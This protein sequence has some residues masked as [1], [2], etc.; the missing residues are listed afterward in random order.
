[1]EWVK[2]GG[3]EPCSGFPPAASSSAAVGGERPA[4][5]ERAPAVLPPW[6]GVCSSRSPRPTTQPMDLEDAA[7]AGAP[8]ARQPLVRIRSLTSRDSTFVNFKNCTRDPV[9]LYWINYEGGEVPYRTIQPGAEYRQQTFCTHPWTY[10]LVPPR[11]D[12]RGAAGAR[13]NPDNV[14][15]DHRR[16]VLPVEE[17]LNVE[18]HYPVEIAWSPETHSAFPAHF[19][20]S[21]AAVLLAHQRCQRGPPPDL[22]GPS[23]RK[24][25]DRE[26]GMTTRSMARYRQAMVAEEPEGPPASPRG[27]GGPSSSSAVAAAEAAAD[28]SISMEIEAEPADEA[29]AGARDLGSLPLD[30]V[31]KCIALA[32]PTEYLILPPKIVAEGGAAPA[33]ADDGS[34]LSHIDSSDFED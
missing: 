23:K 34:D 5:S 25:A 10:K 15:A 14:V 30:V 31:L 1:M 9:R 21:V 29:A 32:A 18:L 8:G 11:A 6:M 20:R 27:S 2:A 17:E 13:V 26:H 4:G 33:A 22:P 7:G 19:R 24:L 12:G 28:F 16:V 3:G